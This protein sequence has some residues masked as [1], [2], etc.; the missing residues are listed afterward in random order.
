MTLTKPRSTFKVDFS[1]KKDDPLDFAFRHC[2]IMESDGAR[3]V[4]T[5]TGKVPRSQSTRKRVRQ[6]IARWCEIHLIIRRLPED[7]GAVIIDLDY[8]METRVKGQYRPGHGGVV[9]SAR[10]FRRTRRACDSGCNGGR[11][12]WRSR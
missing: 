12:C 8:I 6:D 2:R 1:E 7:G 9:T 10:R 5:F 11:G 4:R 3:L